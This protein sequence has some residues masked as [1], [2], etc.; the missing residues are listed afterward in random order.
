MENTQS[1]KHNMEE[2]VLSITVLGVGQDGI[3]AVGAIHQHGIPGVHCAVA[4]VDVAALQKSP[5]P[6]KRVL[7]TV[8]QPTRLVAVHGTNI[9]EGD[10]LGELIPFSTWVLFIIAGLDKASD[11]LGIDLIADAYRQKTASLP[12][13]ERPLIVCLL[14][15]PH[16]SQGDNSNLPTENTIAL[17]KDATDATLIIDHNKLS[18]LADPASHDALLISH[19]MMLNAVQSI[20]SFLPNDRYLDGDFKEL[21]NMMRRSG[22]TCLGFGTG[23]GHQRAAQALDGAYH[24]PLFNPDTFHTAHHVLVSI[25]TSTPNEPAYTEVLAITNALKERFGN[26]NIDIMWTDRY[27][28]SLGDKLQI[29][30]IGLGCDA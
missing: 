19:D 18:A 5:V 25:T 2:R 22:H 26:P 10:A 11:T 8:G 30:L 29:T 28:E 12:E 1:T 21:A 15:L 24:S 27:D 7:S 14:S 16:A 20:A 6:T 13:K 23:E 17:L 9:V 4:D 3:N